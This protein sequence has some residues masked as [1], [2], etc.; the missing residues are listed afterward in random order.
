MNTRKAQA[1]LEFLMTYGWAILVVL[2]AIG[3]L[4]F[5]GVLSPE[6][7]LP[8]KCTLQPGIACIDHKVTPGQVDVVLK[9]GYG[10]DI[11]VDTITVQ[12]CGTITPATT[13]TNGGDNV[14]FNIPCTSPIIGSKYNGMLNISYTNQDSGLAR[15]NIGDIVGTVE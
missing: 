3:A 7:F 6:K 13:M 14:E 4:A 1:A 2:I 10:S 11:V 15:S 8:A 5:F 9:N 12:K